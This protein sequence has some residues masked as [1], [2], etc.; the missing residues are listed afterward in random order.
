MVSELGQKDEGWVKTKVSLRE[1]CVRE[2]ERER[3]VRHKI[4]VV[5][6]LFC[7]AAATTVNNGL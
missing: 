2:R 6:S 7:V 4:L 5:A 1:L 3:V